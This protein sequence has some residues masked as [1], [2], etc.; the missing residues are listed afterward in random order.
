[1]SLGE[2]KEC[3]QEAFEKVGMF[4]RVKYYLSQLSGGQQQ[5]VAVAR[6]FGG[7]SSIFFVDELMGNL[8]SKNG[9]VV[10]V[11]FGEFYCEGAIICMVMYDSRFTHNTK[12]TIQ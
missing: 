10:M 5:R 11:L 4:Y 7:K 12:Q 3:V 2:R 1:M 6:V 9:E 8:D